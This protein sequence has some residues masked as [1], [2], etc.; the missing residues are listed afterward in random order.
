MD[1]RVGMRVG[2]GVIG[3]MD[4]CVGFLVG[5]RVGVGVRV[6]VGFVCGYECGCAC[7]RGGERSW[8]CARGFW[9]GLCAWVLGVVVRVSLLVWRRR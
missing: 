5:M 3:R 1:M 4:M 9:V 8:G 2:V 6:R 7:G